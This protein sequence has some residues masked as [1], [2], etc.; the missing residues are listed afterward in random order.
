MTRWLTRQQP[1]LPATTLGAAWHLAQIAVHMLSGCAHWSLADCERTVLF[2]PMHAKGGAA[3]LGKVTG[4]R[5]PVASRAGKCKWP[6]LLRRLR[7]VCY[8]RS[9]HAL[10]AAVAVG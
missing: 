10:V 9:G 5:A 8:A 3:M 7:W 6:H 4:V 1:Q 2:A